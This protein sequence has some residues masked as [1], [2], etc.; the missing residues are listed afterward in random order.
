MKI[1]VV[2]FAALR[3]QLGI[4]AEEIDLPA[5]V[6]TVAGLRSHLVQRGGAWQSVLAD[7]RLIRVAVNQD[8]AQAG[9]ALK[10][11]DEIAFFP[12]VTGG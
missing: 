8:M 4:S 6:T 7:K 1:K 11:G 12:P 5:G 10:P 2:F 3:E 9:S